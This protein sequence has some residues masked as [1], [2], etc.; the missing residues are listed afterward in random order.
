MAQ[1]VL[2]ATRVHD[3]ISVIEQLNFPYLISLVSGSPKY[4]SKNRLSDMRTLSPLVSCHVVFISEVIFEV[5]LFERTI[6][7]TLS[8]KI[9]EVKSRN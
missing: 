6:A 9:P 1:I 7:A 2:P 5:N 3:I 8:L 4:I